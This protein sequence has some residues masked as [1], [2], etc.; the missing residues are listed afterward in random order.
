MGNQKAI[1]EELQKLG[2][3]TNR[4]GAR[5]MR[6]LMNDIQAS[7]EKGVTRKLIYEKLKDNGFKITYGS[8]LV[9]LKRLRKE[10][11]D[12]AESTA[13]ERSSRSDSA[14]TSISSPHDTSPLNAGKQTNRGHD[15]PPPKPEDTVLERP[16]GITP[17]RWSEMQQ[18]HKAELRRQRNLLNGENK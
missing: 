8:F 16:Q 10:M 1:R 11:R 6:E 9:T 13:T 3:S 7:I 12:L 17:G 2:D 15:P 18:K 5:V 4:P 14:V